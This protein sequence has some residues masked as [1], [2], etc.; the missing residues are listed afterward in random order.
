MDECGIKGM[1]SIL[2]SI[3][4]SVVTITT[5]GYGEMHPTGDLSKIIVIC[6]ISL[7]WLLILVMALHYGATLTDDFKS[8]KPNKA[9]SADAKSRAAD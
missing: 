1:H 8:F 7:T 4:F 2:D 6:Q 5:T 9:N 3:Y